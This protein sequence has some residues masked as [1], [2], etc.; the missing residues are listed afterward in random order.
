MTKQTA[1]I[2]VLGPMASEIDAL[3]AALTA[4]EETVL[5]GYRCTAG[6]LDGVPVVT[7]RNLIGM[8][9]AAAATA[10]AAQRFS[11]RCVIIQGTSGA[12]DP[13]LH[14]GDLILGASLIEMGSYYTPHRD[15]GAG[16]GFNDYT[17]P[18]VQLAVNGEVERVRTLHS[19]PALLAIAEAV[20]YAHGARVT[21]TISSGDIW[22]RELDVIARLHRECGSLCEEME[23]FA[24]AQVCWMLG[25]PML[26]VR[27]VSNSEWHADEKFDESVGL[28]CQDYCRRLIA[29]IDLHFGEGKQA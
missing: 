6:L 21:G 11:P 10:L 24:V 23:G 13:A 14:R 8:V 28:L 17:F 22:N 26:A 2:L 1:P 7:V 5:G 4:P 18:G 27:V 20:P 16:S 12:H 19:D 9:N 3:T 29:Q 25:L 15:A